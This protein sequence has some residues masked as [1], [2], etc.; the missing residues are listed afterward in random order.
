[1]AAYTAVQIAGFQTPKGQPARILKSTGFDATDVT[2]LKIDG[3]NLP[4]VA[5]GTSADAL[6]SGTPGGP[7]SASPVRLRTCRPA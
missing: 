3:S 6:A 2:V 5:L 1:V 4:T 7:R